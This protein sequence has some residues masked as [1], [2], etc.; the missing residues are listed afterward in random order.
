VTFGTELAAVS[1][2]PAYFA[3]TFHLGVAMAAAAGSAFAFTNL[4]T[5]PFGGLLSDALPRRRTALL[6]LLAG[7]VIA[8]LALARMDSGWKL[9]MGVCLVALA[10]VFIQGGNGA[11][12][13]MVPLVNRRSGGQIAGMAGAY[14]TSAA[15][16]SPRSSPLTA[17]TPMCCSSPSR[18]APPR[19]PS[20]CGG[21][22]SRPARPVPSP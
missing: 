20:P 1:L 21:C 4:I 7:A 5:R 9:W 8:F 14:A 16:S 3:S 6:V 2:L 12:Y 11:V 13:A 22:P 17:V 18:A 19:W 10:S 15:W